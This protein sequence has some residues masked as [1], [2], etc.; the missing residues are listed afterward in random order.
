[1]KCCCENKRHGQN[2]CSILTENDKLIL[3]TWCRKGCKRRGETT[4]A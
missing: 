3:C 4:D 1:M 2:G